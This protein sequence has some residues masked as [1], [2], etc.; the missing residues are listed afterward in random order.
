MKKST[1][2]P[3]V[4]AAACVLLVVSLTQA[5]GPPSGPRLVAKPELFK[6]LTEPPCSYCSTQHRKG[7]IRNE[8]R[9]LAWLRASH[10]GGAVPLRHFLSASRVINDT[11]GLFFYDP[12][13]GYVAA[14]Q[15]DYGYKFYGWRN[16][17]MVV[18]SRNG[19]L[20]SA[21][22]GVAFEGPDKGKKLT[23]IASMVTDWRHWLELQPES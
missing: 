9:V 14:Y 10:N 11:Y 12:D 22:S 21:L 2:R 19:S 13:G 7:L 15:K 20:Y 18:Q 17:S 8:D 6:P 3:A 1:C 16:G 4:V 23:R 5:E